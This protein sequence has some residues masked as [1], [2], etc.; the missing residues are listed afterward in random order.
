MSHILIVSFLQITQEEWASRI[1][2]ITRTA[3]RY[4]K[5]ALERAWTLIALVYVQSHFTEPVVRVLT[6]D[7]CYIRTS[8]H[9][10]QC[11]IPCSQ[12]YERSGSVY[13]LHLS[14]L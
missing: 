6:A 11:S 8:Y 2:Q 4:T 5:T 10:L 1:D 9:A 12:P 14:F 13:Q 3:S 7:Q